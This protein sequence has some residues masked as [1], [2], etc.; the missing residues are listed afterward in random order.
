[1][2]D[3][4]PKD[5]SLIRTAAGVTWKAPKHYLTEEG[6]ITVLALVLRPFQ[7][8]AGCISVYL[9]RPIQACAK[10][11]N[12]QAFSHVL[13]SIEF[14]NDDGSTR[15]HYPSMTAMLNISSFRLYIN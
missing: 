6:K 11:R 12:I 8:T 7:G 14:C 1:M 4:A 15:F 13:A 5:Q 2:S 9:F 3:V 10:W